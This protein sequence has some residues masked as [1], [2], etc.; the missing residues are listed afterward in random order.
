MV[1]YGAIAISMQVQYPKNCIQLLIAIQK[2]IRLKG[3]A[4]I[5]E[6]SFM[7]V[8]EEFVIQDTQPPE[9]KSSIFPHFLKLNI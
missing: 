1:L 3:S 6:I 5:P 2:D 9:H 4:V 7:Q 8:K